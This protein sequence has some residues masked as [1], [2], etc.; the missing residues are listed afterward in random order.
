MKRIFTTVVLASMAILV[1]CAQE[2]VTFIFSE[3]LYKENLKKT[4]EQNISQLLTNINA[5][6]ESK[7]VVSF[8]GVKISEQAKHEFLDLWEFMPFS[9]DDAVN[10]EKCLQTVTGYQ[11]R[12]LPVTILDIDD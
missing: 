9:C 3:G 12:G 5:A 7:S 4:A 6:A 2:K 1:I 8:N 10:V 11:V